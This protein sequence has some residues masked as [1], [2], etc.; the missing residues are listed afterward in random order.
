MLI[1]PSFKESC[2][3]FTTSTNSQIFFCSFRH[4]NNY[5]KSFLKKEPVFNISLGTA[6]FSASISDIMC[7]MG[8]ELK[9]DD[10]DGFHLIHSAVPLTHISDL[11]FSKDDSDSYNFIEE[12]MM[13]GD[14]V[15]N[16]NRVL[17][18]A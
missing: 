13:P 14:F 17:T 6:N 8:E 18:P 7:V 11:Q 4:L 3:Q 2:D 5:K 12:D 16:Q 1:T 9:I 10:L 15:A